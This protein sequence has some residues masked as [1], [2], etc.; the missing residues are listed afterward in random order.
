[1]WI[2]ARRRFALSSEVFDGLTA[3][4]SKSTWTVPEIVPAASHRHSISANGTHFSGD[5]QNDTISLSVSN[6]DENSEIAKSARGDRGWLCKTSTP[7]SNPGGAS[8]FKLRSMGPLQIPHLAA[9]SRSFGR[10]R[11]LAAS[12]LPSGARLRPQALLR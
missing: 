6:F 12:R 2:S 3:I 4:A 1:M 7:G 9:R 10:C 5:R 11:H 8:K